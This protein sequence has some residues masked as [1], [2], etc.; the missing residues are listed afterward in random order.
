MYS[1]PFPRRAGLL[2]DTLSFW[3][4]EFPWANRWCSCARQNWLFCFLWKC[5]YL[6]QFEDVFICTVSGRQRQE[7]TM[8]S[9]PAWAM[10]RLQTETVSQKEQQQQHGWR[11]WQ[12]AVFGGASW[13][14]AFLCSPSSTGL[15][16]SVM[17]LFL[18]AD[19]W[20]LCPI[21]FALFW[22]LWVEV[23]DLWLA[24]SCGLWVVSFTSWA[25]LSLYLLKYSLGPLV[26]RLLLRAATPASSHAACH[27]S[28]GLSP[29]SLCVSVSLIFVVQLFLLAFLPARYP[30]SLCC[31][32][33]L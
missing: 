12:P 26:P 13:Q 31:I 18:Q 32:C 20:L 33:H 30:F 19:L 2:S 29:F 1:P 6:F 7:S 21:L 11:S 3:L 22:H 28:E 16:I 23:P 8:R 9:R 25:I 17:G 10:S 14:D 27:Y 5:H 24:E 4:G 15:N